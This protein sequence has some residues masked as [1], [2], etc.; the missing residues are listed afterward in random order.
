MRVI[1]CNN[2]TFI[3]TF[4][5][6]DKF[7]NL[8]LI[9]CVE[10]MNYKPR[11]KPVIKGKRTIGTAIIRGEHIMNIIIDEEPYQRYAGSSSSSSSYRH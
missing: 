3:G 9:D 11:R 8:V 7:M 1:L 6:Y 10:Y 5:A 4:S 2:R